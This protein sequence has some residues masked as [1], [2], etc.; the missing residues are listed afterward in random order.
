MNLFSFVKERVNMLDV[1]RE[2]VSLKR[3]GLYYKGRC[4]FHQEKDASFTVSPH[5]EIFY[6]FGCHAS[7]DAIA[8]ISQIEHCTQLEAAQLL[9][10]KY[11]LEVPESVLKGDGIPLVSTDEKQRFYALCEHI[12]IW[13]HQQLRISNLATTYVDSRNIDAQTIKKFSLGYFPGGP[14][15][16]KA[17]Q[18]HLQPHGFL[19]K[20]LLD[21]GIVLEGKF[22]GKT[23]YCPFEE[24]IIFPITDHLG[25]HCGFG[26]RV[27]RPQDE[28]A[29]YYNSRESA[30]FNKGSLLFGLEQAKSA[31]QER[32]TAF[33]VEGYIDCVAMAQYG[34]S[35]TVATLGTACTNTHLHQLARYVERVYVLYDG[36]NAGLQAVLRLTHLCWDANIELWV[37]S[38]PKGED[39][40]SFLGGGHTVQNLVQHARDIFSF[41]VQSSSALFHQ[42]SLKKKLAVTH[43]MV[44]MIANVGDQLKKDILLQEMAH[45]TNI[46]LETLRRACHAQHSMNVQK[47]VPQ[48]TETQE[49]IKK[50]ADH[51]KKLFALLIKYPH[52]LTTDESILL[53]HELTEPL[54]TA[55]NAAAKMPDHALD[56]ALA[57]VSAHD[58]QLL[59]SI[60]MMHDYLQEKDQAPI[61][62]ECLRQHWRTLS[63]ALKERIAQAQHQHDQQTVS[64]LLQ[65]LQELKKRIVN[66]SFAWQKK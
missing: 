41:F 18:Q 58:Q 1:A 50:I 54:K 55:L 19:L 22:A 20:D 56:A 40:A 31:L 37:I 6:C 34:Y 33:L 23:H 25:R 13:C 35:N 62:H 45:T 27:F 3:A 2:Y 5:K 26:G 9:V 10:E 14:K 4:P 28:R 65:Q 15:A 38:L 11:A 43:H 17:L 66:W 48:T 53:M 60:V 46:P 16:L 59:Q 39:P 44:A 64:S 57:A 47:I 42:Q 30:F 36:D 21:A 7:G 52:L 61:M 63:H 32:Q 49:P 51:E 12:A 24:R 8:F 29:K